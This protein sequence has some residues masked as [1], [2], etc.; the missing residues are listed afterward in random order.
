MGERGQKVK[1]F[2]Y[3]CHEDIIHSMVI[4]AIVSLKVAR[5]ILNILIRRKKCNFVW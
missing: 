1:I 5:R 4:I 2:S 3:E